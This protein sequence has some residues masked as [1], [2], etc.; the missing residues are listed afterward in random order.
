MI[1][2]KE[3]N[4]SLVIPKWQLFSKVCND[5]DFDIPREEKF[6]INSK[7]EQNL[8]KD[9]LEFRKDPNI[10]AASDLLSSAIVINHIEI[11]KD[12]AEY[13]KSQKNINN[14]I[15]NLSDSI[16]GNESDDI[17]AYDSN[18]RI[19]MLRHFLTKYPKNPIYWIELARLYT[20]KGYIK[21][22]RRSVITSLNLAPYDRYIVRAGF[23][24]FVHI[25][26]Y[27]RA[28]FYVNKAANFTSDPWLKA[29]ELNAAILNEMKLGKVRKLNP[30]VLPFDKVFHYSELIESIG[31]LEYKSGNNR[32]AKKKFKLAWSDPSGNVVTHGE[33]ILRNIF[34]SLA[35]SANLDFS[36][37]LEAL[38]WQ[39]FYKLKLDD[40]LTYVRDWIL[41]EPYSTH[42]FVCGSDIAC[43]ARIPLEAIKFA[44]E[45]LI[46]NPNDLSLKNNLAFAYLRSN[47]IDK[48]E[49]ILNTYPKSLSERERIF[50]FAT[51]GLL[52]YKKGNINLG[53]DLYLESIK[54]CRKNNNKRLAAKASLHL[55]I[56][57]I[58]SNS[59]SA[60]SSIEKALRIS[61][62]Y[63]SPDI[64]LPKDYIKELLNKAT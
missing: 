52:Y 49:H 21:K 47:I 53:R 54:L 12:V 6:I 40:A 3:A 4:R 55:A 9:Y 48:A 15:I 43:H 23:R 57:E 61:K 39:S 59:K 50:Y 28:F 32:K 34:P 46:A 38:T 41:E 30:K 58:E 35:E 36:K 62:D 37:S 26:E 27:D 16:L 45:G 8:E 25:D 20:I 63:T 24:F 31:M 56:A 60:P 51:K 14:V 64:L 2:D 18:Y 10:L 5:R 1:E 42:P 11:A 22:A 44:K 7:T 13:I 17:S 33:W 19:G 29:T